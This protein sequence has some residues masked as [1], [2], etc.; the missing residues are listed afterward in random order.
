MGEIY[1]SEENHLEGNFC[2][3]VFFSGS[4]NTFFKNQF[5]M[6]LKKT[7]ST[8]CLWRKPICISLAIKGTKVGSRVQWVG[9]VLGCGGRSSDLLTVALTNFRR[10]QQFSDSVILKNPMFSLFYDILKEGMAAHSSVLAW[11]IP[12]TEE[13]GRIQSMVSQRARHDWSD[14]AQHMVY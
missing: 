1:G 11:R 5:S 4:S 13:P 3:I 14:L 9:G 2:M 7:L 6:W 8:L 12:W 10:A